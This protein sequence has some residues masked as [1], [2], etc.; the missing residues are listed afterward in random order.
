MRR[1][2]VLAL[3]QSESFRPTLRR[4]SGGDLVA[5]RIGYLKGFYLGRSLDYCRQGLQQLR[6]SGGV[7]SLRVRFR[8]PESGAYGFR[9]F[10]GDHGDLITKSLLLAKHWENFLLDNAVKLWG[11][12]R[13]EFHCDMTCKH[14]YAPLVLS[15]WIQMIWVIP[16]EL[17]RE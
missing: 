17:R 5:S 12:I 9:A 7:V 1:E 14:T 15:Y 2:G 8:V 16:E 6:I 13:L 4:L 3:S 11:G 10:G